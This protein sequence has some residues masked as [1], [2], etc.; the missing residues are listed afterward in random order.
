MIK[1]KISKAKEH[2]IGGA[3]DYRPDSDFDPELLQKGV[4]KE[5]GDHGLP[6]SDA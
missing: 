3:G 4:D 2:F 1:V 5:V 6:Q